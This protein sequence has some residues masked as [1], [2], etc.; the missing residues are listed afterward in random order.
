MSLLYDKKIYIGII[1]LIIGFLIGW[2]AYQTKNLND[3]KKNLEASQEK[4]GQYVGEIYKNMNADLYASIK[5]KDFVQF[6]TTVIEKRCPFYKPD[7]VTYRGCLS[8]W[9]EELA[10]KSMVEQV[11]EVHAYCSMFTKKYTDETS[12]EGTELFLKCSIYKLQS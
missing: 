10:N 11:D 12:L 9:E 4:T 6:A 7:G 8:D 1:L 5:E 2:Y 3:I